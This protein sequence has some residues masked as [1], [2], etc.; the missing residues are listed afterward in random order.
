MAF[1]SKRL[2]RFLFA[3]IALLPFFVGEYARYQR[4][5]FSCD[6][7]LFIQSA[8]EK[9]HI[10]MNFHFENGLGSYNATGTHVI[11]GNVLKNIHKH[12]IFDYYRESDYLILIS[13]GYDSN[14]VTTDSFDT[15]IP[16][17]FRYSKR[18]ISLKIGKGNSEG[19]IISMD[20]TPVLYCKLPSE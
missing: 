19:Y 5:H 17:F 14:P 13:R 18:G 12:F 20:K 10:T 1:N 15:F 6:S 2:I 4:T 16:D 3:I 8:E 7:E 9:I 11:N